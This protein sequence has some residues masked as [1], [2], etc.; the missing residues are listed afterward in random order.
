MGAEERIVETLEKQLQLL[1][2]RSREKNCEPS[3]LVSL[4]DVMVSISRILLELEAQSP[5]LEIDPKILGKANCG[6]D[7]RALG[8]SLG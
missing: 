4:S 6:K 2:E 5:K 3:E 8:T 1:S 7:L